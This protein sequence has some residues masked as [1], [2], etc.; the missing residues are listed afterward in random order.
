MVLF[1]FFI[2]ANFNI[3]RKNRPWDR[4]RVSSKL[5][6]LSVRWYWW[7]FDRTYYGFCS[8]LMKDACYIY[9]LLYIYIYLVRYRAEQNMTALEMKLGVWNKSM[10]LFLLSCIVWMYLIVFVSRR[11]WSSGHYLASCTRL[12]RALHAIPKFFEALDLRQHCT[13]NLSSWLWLVCSGGL[14]EPSLLRSA[15]GSHPGLLPPRWFGGNQWTRHL[16]AGSV[17]PPE[18]STQGMPFLRPPPPRLP[19]CACTRAWPEST[20]CSFRYGILFVEAAAVGRS[21]KFGKQQQ[22]SVAVV[23]TVAIAGAIANIDRGSKRGGE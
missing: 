1:C 6:K 8:T 2:D 23:A 22:W 9:I 10:E 13:T 18:Q 20:C 12:A 17:G 5:F 14:N 16:V 7:C 4:S 19:G 3:S 21:S 15:G 11:A